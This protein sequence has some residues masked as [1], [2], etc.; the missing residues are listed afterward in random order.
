TSIFE[1]KMAIQLS[2]KVH[3]SGATS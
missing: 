2:Q 1:R 3:L